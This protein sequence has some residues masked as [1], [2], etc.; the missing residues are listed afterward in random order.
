MIK[1]LLVKVIIYHDM[2]VKMYFSGRDGGTND[3][4]TVL[5]YKGA[6]AP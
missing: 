6:L 1:V 2:Y 3:S 5:Y 4:E